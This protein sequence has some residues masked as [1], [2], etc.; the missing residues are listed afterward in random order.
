MGWPLLQYDWYP[1]KKRE[2][3]T[4]TCTQGQCHVKVK[5][6]QGD[7][8]TGQGTPEIA[9]K[10]LKSGDRQETLPPSSQKEPALPKP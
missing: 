8:C 6:G 9:G 2:I 3:R 10:L 7:T 1:Y 4:Q 5:A